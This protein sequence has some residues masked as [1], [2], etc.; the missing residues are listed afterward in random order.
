MR[1]LIAAELRAFRNLVVH[2]S[3]RGD[4]IGL[5]ITLVCVSFGSLLLARRILPEEAVELLR[6]DP[7][8]TLARLAF[9]IATLPVLFLSLGLSM[10]TMQ[11][12]LFMRE[13]SDLLLTAPVP[14]HA[15]LWLGFFRTILSCVLF[16][17]PMA[18]PVMLRVTYAVDPESGFATYAA[19]AL[20]GTLTLAVA[21]APL[22]AG[23]T[24][25]QI[26]LMRWF[27]SPRVR[28]AMQLVTILLLLT[29]SLVAMA[30]LLGDDTATRA[31][32]S[33]LEAGS[34][35]WSFELLALLPA[36][37]IGLAPD[38]VIVL[39]VVA[40]V[41]APFIVL[42]LAGFAYPRARENATVAARP[43]FRARRAK[44]NAIRWPG[45][46]VASGLRRELAQFTNDPGGV[47]V[48][49]FLGALIVWGHLTDVGGAPPPGL[50]E[51]IALAMAAMQRFAIVLTL[52]SMLIV[53]FA[54]TSERKQ[55]DVLASS[56]ASREG[57]LRAKSCGIA[58]PL[59]WCWLVSVGAMIA[60]GTPASGVGLF[61]ILSVPMLV[62]ALAC[63][64]AAS[65]IPVF[66]LHDP[67]SPGAQMTA[68]LG[69]QL[70]V[71]AVDVGLL[72]VLLR[73]AKSARH[74]MRDV[75]QHETASATSALA[76]FVASVVVGGIVLFA[77]GYGIAV[78][79]VKQA[80]EGIR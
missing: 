2:P 71:L 26:V 52:T 30:G 79:N 44:G 70:L 24:V 5:L 43:L 33:M 13:D 39:L 49:V 42:P 55:L 63:V 20:A 73:A 27:A 38:P 45:T 47:I 54:C 32:S 23:V 19:V 9:G 22:I 46:L 29:F 10:S 76:P 7:D 48:Y 59:V 62:A 1:P 36:L 57:L 11:T 66:A 53:P 18:I 12:A 78:R 69:P 58:V 60:T 17:L 16:G 41:A 67:D 25:V 14:P 61:A 21:L 56:P 8:G 40:G 65:T 68:V 74:S 28:V 3:G 72:Y 31:V 77:I 51:S 35:P 50:P 4:F 75:I 6:D 64:L 37:A 15:T 34:M 80:Y